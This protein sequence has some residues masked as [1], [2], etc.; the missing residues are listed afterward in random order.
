MSEQIDRLDEIRAHL[1]ISTPTMHD[2]AWAL[3]EITRLRRELVKQHHTIW[4]LTVIIGRVE[5]AEEDMGMPEQLAD[6]IDTTMRLLELPQDD[7][8][9][10]ADE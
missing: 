7:A 1:S 6:Y 10:E 5:D 3:E 2:M 8:I 4:Q 9:E